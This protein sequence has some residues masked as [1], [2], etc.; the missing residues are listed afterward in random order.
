MGV[1]PSNCGSCDSSDGPQYQLSCHD[2]NFLYCRNC[3]T[4][5]W[6]TAKDELVRCPHLRCREVCGFMPLHPLGQTLHLDNNFHDAECIEKIRNQPEVMNN[7]LGFTRDEAVATLQHVYSMFED[8]IMDPIALGGIP[9]YITQSARDSF[10]A[11][12]SSNPFYKKL[13]KELVSVPKMTTTPLELEEDL[14]VV[15]THLLYTYTM[16]Q[17]YSELAVWSIPLTDEQAIV[18]AACANYSA[19][20]ELK[21]NWTDI[22]RKWVD[23][24]AWRHLERFAPLGGGAAE[25]R[26]EN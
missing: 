12:A 4:K 22:V 18:E 5:T 10:D 3:L 21:K 6:F 19:V 1:M 13:L 25:R 11:N 7:L 17:F 14:N 8:Q 2:S 9:G 24:L 20:Q 26:R 16:R 15:L 23:L